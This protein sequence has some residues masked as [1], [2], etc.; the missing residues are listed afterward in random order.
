MKILVFL[1]LLG[2]HSAAGVTHSLK[3]FYTGSSQ[4]P[5]FPE[6]V[7][8][9][10]VDDV[11]MIHYDSNTKKAE[12]KQDWMDT[13]SADN[14]QYL[15]GQT[16]GLKGTQPVFKG[17]IETLKQRFNQT[18]GVHVYQNMYGCEW[19]DETGEVNGFHQFG[20]DGEDFIVFD[21]KTLTWIAPKQQA[22]ITKHK[23]DK[24]KAFND[25]WSNYHSEIC[26]DWL[27]KYVNY[28]RSSLMRTELPSTHSLL[29]KTPSSPVSCFATGFYP[30]RV[31]MFWRKD[32]VELHEDVERGEILPNHD[33]SFQMSVK[34]DVSSIAPEDWRK[35]ECVFQLSGVKDDIIINLDEIRKPG[36][37][38]GAVIGGVVVLLLLVVGIVGFFLWK[39]NKKGKEGF[40]LA[41]TSDTSS[42]NSQQQIPKA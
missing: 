32:G 41:S 37:P 22:V 33:G 20:Y 28:G 6:F 34:L 15:A 12:P 30:D 11:Q 38:L 39:K 42:D 31:M 24:D 29:Q 27:K 8:V 14:P 18:G 1:A 36:F 17:N 5:N 26:V 21:L 7:T 23:W 10:L 40:K 2:L 16:E 25:Y 13:F 19:D 9:G 35:Y 3:Y 4:V